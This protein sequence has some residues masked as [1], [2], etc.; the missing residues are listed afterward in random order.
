MKYV[1]GVNT[2]IKFDHKDIPKTRLIN[3][4][5]KIG[6][7]HCRTLF[8]EH[9][10]FRTSKFWSFSFLERFLSRFMLNEKGIIIG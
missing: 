6:R 3:L 5:S 9:I 1:Y 7:D 10:T 8:L 2:T 4:M